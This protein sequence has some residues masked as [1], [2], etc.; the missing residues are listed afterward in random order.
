MPARHA[1]A[2]LSRSTGLQLRGGAFPLACGASSPARR[3]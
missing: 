2:L 3:R 1:L